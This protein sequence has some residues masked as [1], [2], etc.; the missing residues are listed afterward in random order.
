[1]ER[2]EDIRKDDEWSLLASA[3]WT[4]LVLHNAFEFII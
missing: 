1:M 4:I 3:T 2:D